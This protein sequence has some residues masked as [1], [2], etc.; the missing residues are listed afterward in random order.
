MQR[1]P[2]LEK[3][4]HYQAEQ[5]LRRS[6]LEGKPYPGKEADLALVRGKHKELSAQKLREALEGPRGSGNARD[7]YWGW[8]PKETAKEGGGGG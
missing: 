7:R 4:K 1:E 8:Y 2:R 5:R 3:V 6:I